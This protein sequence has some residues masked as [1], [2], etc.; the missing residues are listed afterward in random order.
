M[1]TGDQILAGTLHSNKQKCQSKQMAA[2]SG[3]E[4]KLCD[5]YMVWANHQLFLLVA[6]NLVFGSL[7]DNQIGFS[8]R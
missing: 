3:E 4:V 5:H 1:S 7:L 2:D 6:T 8:N